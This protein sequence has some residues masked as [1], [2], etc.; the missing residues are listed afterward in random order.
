MTIRTRNHIYLGLHIVCSLFFI[1]SM[2]LVIARGSH[3]YSRMPF[4]FDSGLAFY[5]FPAAVSGILFF[6]LLGALVSFA[7]YRGFEKTPSMEITY[8]LGVIV[9]CIA[10]GI[11]ILVPVLE[12]GHS[13]SF[14]LVAVGRIVVAG[15]IACVL[16]IFFASAFSSNEEIQNQERNLTIIIASSCLCAFFY[17]VNTNVIEP[18]IMVQMGYRR[19][20]IVIRFL[21]VACSLVSMIQEAIASG[22]RAYLLKMVGVVI[23]TV[24][25]SILCSCTNW[26]VFGLSIAFVSAGVLIYLKVIHYL[27]NIWN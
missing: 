18:F 20:F 24:G 6:P 27:S 8:F 21:V 11:R 1:L 2:I 4:G 5:S 17:P 14:L 9:E 22:S 25:Y 23:F 7:I 19:F 3:L 10:E 26:I 13:F 16:S 15:R 12:L